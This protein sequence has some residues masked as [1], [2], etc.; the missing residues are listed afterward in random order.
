MQQ[1]TAKP[2][3]LI[4]VAI[5]AVILVIVG[6]YYSRETKTSDEFVLA[7]KGLGSIVLI[8]T[9]LATYTGNGTISGGGNS[10][11]YPYGLWPGI[12]F[13]LPAI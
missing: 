11:A 4:F 2:I 3:L 5:Y 7:G 10:L 8:G 9:F 12:F 1:L 6:A 13:A